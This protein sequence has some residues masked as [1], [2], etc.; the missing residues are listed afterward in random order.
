[1]NDWVLDGNYTRTTSIKWKEV[2]MV[3]WIDYSFLRTLFQAIHRGYLPCHYWR[4]TMARH[5]QSGTLSDSFHEGINR[6][7][8]Y[9]KLWKK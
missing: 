5:R 2:D 6:P 9:Q 3:I 8:E 4:R 1:M 7:V